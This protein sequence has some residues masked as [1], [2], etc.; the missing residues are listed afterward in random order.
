MKQIVVFP[1]G[2]LSD[3]DRKSL[4]RSG[5]V[6]VEADD[7]SRVV[8]LLPTMPLPVDEILLAALDALT[9]GHSGEAKFVKALAEAL[10]RRLTQRPA[11]SP[12]ESDSTPTT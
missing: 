10:R 11:T 7:P 8:T 3:K 4:A 6:V 9:A 1:R 2:Q 12:A 5:V